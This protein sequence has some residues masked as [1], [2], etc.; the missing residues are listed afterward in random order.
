M[1]YQRGDDKA[2]VDKIGVDVMKVA[3]PRRETVPSFIG[4]LRDQV[5]L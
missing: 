3:L 5:S 4:V 1:V 2:D